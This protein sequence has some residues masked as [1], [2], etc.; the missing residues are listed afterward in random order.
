MNSKEALEHIIFVAKLDKPISSVYYQELIEAKE[1]IEKDLE[2][3]E[4]IKKKNV[5]TFL[6]PC[7]NNAHDYSMKT[8][9]FE[10]LT[11]KEFKLL[12]EW[13]EGK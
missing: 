3:L 7:C 5:A 8:I 4:L 11:D 6:I 2:V 12:K 13:L 1:K 10:P 9:G